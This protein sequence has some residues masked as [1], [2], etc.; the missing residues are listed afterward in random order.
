L[1]SVALTEPA[2][3]EG[4]SSKPGEVTGNVRASDRSVRRYLAQEVSGG[5]EL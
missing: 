1:R 5:E 3:A 2:R 4:R